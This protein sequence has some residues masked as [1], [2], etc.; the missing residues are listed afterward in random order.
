MQ[1]RYSRGDQIL[2]ASVFVGQFRWGLQR[3]FR[4]R[5]TLSVDRT[6]LKIVARWRYDWSANVLEKFSKS[7]KMGA[8]FVCTTSAI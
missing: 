8:K 5:K 2:I 1:L 6:D 4:E 3:F 7:E